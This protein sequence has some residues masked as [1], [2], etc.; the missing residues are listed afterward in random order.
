M[1]T[2]THSFSHWCSHWP[3]LTCTL[4]LILRFKLTQ[5]H[6]NADTCILMFIL[7]PAP[8]WHWPHSHSFTIIFTLTLI[9][10]NRHTDT[11][12]E[13]LKWTLTLRD[14]CKGLLEELPMEGIWECCKVWMMLTYTY[15]C[16]LISTLP[17]THSLWHSTLT[18][19]LTLTE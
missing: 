8:H 3:M 5:N 16:T 4:T 2:D 1:K 7:K 13:T 19:T 18:G 10:A 11:H 17:Q 14:I 12:T 15:P 9:H 6:T